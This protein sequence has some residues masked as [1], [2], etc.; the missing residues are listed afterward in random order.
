MTYCEHINSLWIIAAVCIGFIM[1]GAFF[2]WFLNKVP[3]GPP[4]QCGPMGTTGM[5]GISLSEFRSLL[6][7]Q[8][9]FPIKLRDLSPQLR[10]EVFRFECAQRWKQKT[11]EDWVHELAVGDVTIENY[12]VDVFSTVASP[13]YNSRGR[14]FNHIT[15]KLSG[16]A[17]EFAEHVG[18]AARD[19]DWD[20][21]TGGEGFLP[22]R[23]AALLKE[24][25][26]ILWYVVTTAKEL[27]S[28]L[29]EVMYL[30]IVKRAGRQ[31]RGTLKGNGDD[32]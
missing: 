29:A 30:N 23:R 8:G 14:W 31:K 28:S 5:P 26:D 24:L 20:M 7:A 11:G 21:N 12:E 32:R 13:I 25:G 4:G 6:S 16:E 3:A 10:D 17:G 1:G 9:W 2:A 27:G 22:E 15:N 18:K 19:D